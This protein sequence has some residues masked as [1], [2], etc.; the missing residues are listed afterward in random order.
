[1]HER[2]ECCYYR[3]EGL[4]MKEQLIF[5]VSSKPTNYEIRSKYPL[6]NQYEYMII[7]TC[8]TLD[9]Y[10]F[11]VT[12]TLTHIKNSSP[13]GRRFHHFRHDFVSRARCSFCA[14]TIYTLVSTQST[15]SLINSSH[16]LGNR[17][18]NFFHTLLR[19]HRESVNS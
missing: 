18:F 14:C 8:I 13:S 2:V 10:F 7:Y 4:A 6:Y 15:S 9:S 17:I 16:D 1:M 5:H 3:K 11:Q 19:S 12:K